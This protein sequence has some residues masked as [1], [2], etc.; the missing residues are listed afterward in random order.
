MIITENTNI[1]FSLV[2][3]DSTEYGY[4]GQLRNGNYLGKLKS[5]SFG[6][7]LSQNTHYTGNI[8]WYFAI[9]PDVKISE[10]LFLD[11]KDEPKSFKLG[12][13]NN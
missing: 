4:Y 3:N 10:K 13:I 11:I 2:I 5:G 12:W 6:Y 8:W 9:N 7:A 1:R